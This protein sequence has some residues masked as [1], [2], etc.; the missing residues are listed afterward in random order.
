MNRYSYILVLL[1]LLSSCGAD[2]HLKKGDQFMAIGEY[3]EASLEY[4]KAYA[5]TPPQKKEERG[6]RAYKVA[7]S[8]RLLNYTAKALAAYRNAARYKYTDTLTYYYTGELERESRD[9]KSAAK[10]YQLY[11][12]NH[13]SDPGCLLGLE[14]CAAAPAFR[15]KGSEYTVREDHL[16]N[17]RYDDYSPVLS[18]DQIFFSSTRKEATGDDVNG[19]TGMKS[20]DIF[21]AKKDEKGKWKRPELVEG[22]INTAY[23]EGA[24]CLTPDG[25]TMYFTR[26]R[27][28]S[29]YPRLAEIYTSSRSD[30]SWGSASLCV[31]SK[32]TLSNYAHPAVSPDGKY[33]YFVSDMPGG[34]GGTDIWRAS[35]TTHG[36]GAVENLGAPINSSGNERFPTFRP[37]GD[38]YYSSDGKIGLGGLDIYCAKYDSTLNKWDVTHLPYP[39]NSNGDDFGM[40]FDGIHNRG[41]FSSNRSNRRGWDKIYTFDCPEIIQTVK[42]WVYEQDGYELP[43]AQVYMIGDDATNTKL[44][45]KLDGSFEQVVKPGVHYLFLASCEGYMNYRHT[46]YLPPNVG[47]VDTTF[48]FPLPSLTIPVL[49]RNVFYAY[50][51]AEILPQSI[52][53][54]NKLTDLLKENPSITIELSSHCDYRGSDAYNERL[55]QHR[56]ESVVKY[57]TAHGISEKRVVAHGYGKKRPKVITPKF[58]EMY[59]FLHAGDTLTVRFIKRLNKAR[60]DSCNALNRRTEF[61]VLR[62]TFDMF[63][64]KG[65][66]KPE[67]VLKK[68]EDSTSKASAPVPH[69]IDAAT[70]KMKTMPNV[71]KSIQSKGTNAPAKDPKTVIKPAKTVVGNVKKDSVAASK[72]IKTVKKDSVATKTTTKPFN[73]TVKSTPVRKP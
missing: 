65:N 56:A 14:S 63:D 61:S 18:E 5:K 1:L 47:S 38:L 50:N 36:I 13:P 48:Q 6:M 24:C 32:D 52:P 11:L 33:L 64:E 8:N 43:K 53:A 22:G 15:D 70:N 19:I 45:L 60:Q 69:K 31:I 7:E 20:G 12:D 46:L 72:M 49:V 16:F 71:S 73:K 54:L 28:D 51:K 9:Y 35:L 30:A 29:K 41:Y 68:V 66:L 10:S 34:L 23:D 25:K 40:T 59:P 27:W 67:T 55:S 39:V 62:T 44:G 4:A 58:A 2:R 57:L 26:C 37:N 42:G 21:T 17:A 3:Y